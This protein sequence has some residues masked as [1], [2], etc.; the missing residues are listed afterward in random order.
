M[1]E[2]LIA[3]LRSRSKGLMMSC[4]VLGFALS[5]C[6]LGRSEIDIMSPATVT[7]MST[8]LVKIVD[9]IDQRKFEAAPGQPSTPSLERAADITNPAITSR[10]YAR[11]RN[12][13]GKALGDIILPEGRTIAALVRAATQKALEDKGYRVVDQ[14]SPDYARAM[15]VSVE[16]TEFWTW[17]S[18]GFGASLSCRAAVR[19][20]G[21]MFAAQPTVIQASA[22]NSGALLI[23]RTFAEVSKQGLDDLTAKMAAQIRPPS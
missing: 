10:A 20:N 3:T 13:Y 4:V 16:V 2:R 23:E 12:G 11:K 17:V 21:S 19:V 18:V 9:V 7:S 6:A 8:A 14:N 1:L 15:P 22:T 5:G